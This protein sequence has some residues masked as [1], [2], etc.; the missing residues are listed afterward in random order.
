MEP[1]VVEERETVGVVEGAT[2]CDAAAVECGEEVAVAMGVVKDGI[3]ADK[4]GA[5]ESNVVAE[6]SWLPMEPPVVEEREAVG[7]VEGATLCDATADVCG[8]EAAVAM[9]VVEDGIDADK[10]GT[11]GS[12]CG[13][14][15]CWFASCPPANEEGDEEAE[16]GTARSDV[17]VIYD[18][19]E[20]QAAGE[21]ARS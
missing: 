17:R 19:V 16:G 11:I 1:P 8:E 7:V 20:E 9:G 3:G 15:W 5:A 6:W 13:A 4:A 10:I 21:V 18:T 2:L 12:V 14:N